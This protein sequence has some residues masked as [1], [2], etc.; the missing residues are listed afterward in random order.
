M[1]CLNQPAASDPSRD[2]AEINGMLDLMDHSPCR[3]IRNG[4]AYSGHAAS[5]HLRAKW[6]VALGRV[7]GSITAEQFIAQI[8]S[9]SILSGRPYAYDC[10][11]DGHGA[12][13]RWLQAALETMR[14]K[15]PTP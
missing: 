8:G 11:A 4:S 5:D 13:A 6:R 1:V 9:T 3:F 10:G 14:T 15:T 12:L 2:Q 7:S